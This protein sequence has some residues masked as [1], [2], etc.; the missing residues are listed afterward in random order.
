MYKLA[1][2]RF[3]WLKAYMLIAVC[4]FTSFS[5]RADVWGYVDEQGLVHLAPSAL[6]ARYELF[7]RSGQSFDTQLDLPREVAV[8]SSRQKLIAFFQVSP[9]FK[10]VRPLMREAARKNKV[11]FELIQALIAVESGYNAKAVSPRG[12]IG[13]MQVIVP[14]AQR[15]GVR[16][17]RQRST[18][19]MLMDPRTNLHTGTRYLAD[20]QRLFPGRLD[21][22]LAAYNAGEGA[23][24]RYN[25]R[26]PPYPETQAYVQTVM[27]L[28]NALKPSPAM[29][30]AM[31][32]RVQLP[33]RVLP[34][35]ALSVS[36]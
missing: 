19:Q 29:L 23:V 24:Q 3:L 8:P 1:P 32:V 34:D 12:A 28:Y 16:G 30:Q 13:L 25:N 10:A 31:R 27:E 6:D 22:A 14:T 11:D 2:Q 5:A 4:L 18:A 35:P 20:L 7:F 15:Y 33:G 9:D 21:L 36:D 26:V 17:D